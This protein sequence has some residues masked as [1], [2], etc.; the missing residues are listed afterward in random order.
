MVKGRLLI[1]L[2]ALKIEGIYT[3]IQSGQTK[4]VQLT[5]S[6]LFEI[7]S[8]NVRTRAVCF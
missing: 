8:N 2:K 6:V 5:F 4:S 7:D 1:R 3:E